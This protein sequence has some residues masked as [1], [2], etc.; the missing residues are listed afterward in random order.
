MARGPCSSAGDG[1]SG[2]VAP[3]ET[4]ST[5]ER[6]RQ[7]VERQIAGARTRRG[8]RGRPRVGLEPGGPDRRWSSRQLHRLGEATSHAWAGAIVFVVAIAWVLVG[9]LTDFGNTWQSILSCSTAIVT[10]VMVFAIQHLQ[11]RE[12]AAVHRK[13]DEILRALPAADN[14]LIAVEEAPDRELE[15][16]ADLNRA[17]RERAVD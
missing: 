3:I 14:R 16:L 2:L 4:L 17:D 1:Y 10:V 15:A 8:R 11:A 6:R 5:V 12:Q 7:K 13:L 9:A